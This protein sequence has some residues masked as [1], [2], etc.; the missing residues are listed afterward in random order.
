MFRPLFRAII[1]SQE[2]FFEE[3]IQCILKNNVYRSKIQRDLYTL[4]Y[5]LHCKVSSN[6]SSCDLMMARNKGRKMS[7]P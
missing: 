2:V 5:K 4:I 7:S 1:R 3:P 6:N